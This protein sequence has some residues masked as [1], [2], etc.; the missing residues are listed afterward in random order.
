MTKR[1][2]AKIYATQ[3]G[4]SGKVQFISDSSQDM[5]D[6]ATRPPSKKDLGRVLRYRILHI[7]MCISFCT[8]NFWTSSSLDHHIFV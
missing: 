6:S 8:V 1:L 2:T 7:A 4:R 5:C 3:G